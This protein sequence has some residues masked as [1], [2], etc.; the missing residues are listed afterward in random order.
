M[1]DKLRLLKLLDDKCDDLRSEIENDF[2]RITW[3]RYNK[4]SSFEDF[5]LD[6]RKV[7]II[8]NYVEYLEWRYKRTHDVYKEGKYSMTEM[9]NRFRK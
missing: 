6:E 8:D 3:A 2:F 9:K 5:A 7:S 4:N 1:A